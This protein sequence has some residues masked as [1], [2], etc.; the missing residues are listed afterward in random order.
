MSTDAQTRDVAQSIVVAPFGIEADHP[1]NCDLLLQC[2]PN[3]RLRSALNGAKPAKDAKTGRPMIPLDQARE[4]SSLIPIPGM[5][6]H[7]NPL[8]RTWTIID[9]LHDNKPLLLEL[10]RHL[11][12]MR[13]ATASDFNGVPTSQGE[14]DVHRMKSLVREMFTLVKDSEAVLVKGAMPSMDDI[15]NLPGRFLLN[16][17]AR[18]HNGQPVYED[19]LAGWEANLHAS[20]M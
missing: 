6:L 19:D 18:V 16:P 14:L 4:M 11:R 7:V 10:S 20:G 13:K 17:G 8:K 12:I 3:C 2:L 5:Q 9:P 15:E 1:R